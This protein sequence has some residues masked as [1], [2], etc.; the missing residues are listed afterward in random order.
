MYETAI[1]GIKVAML[2]VLLIIAK[3]FIN[4]VPNTSSQLTPGWAIVT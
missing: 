2:N 1:V 3:N 4:Y